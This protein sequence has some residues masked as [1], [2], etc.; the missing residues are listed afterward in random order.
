MGLGWFGGNWAFSEARGLFMWVWGVL[1][2][3]RVVWG[4]RLLWGCTIFYCVREGGRGLCGPWGGFWGSWD[5]VGGH[6]V[7]S[8]GRL[9]GTLEML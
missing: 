3:L 7:I 1:M 2:D 9:S 4:H 5:V 8:G 6:R